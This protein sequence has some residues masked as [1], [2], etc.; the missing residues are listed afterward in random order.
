[1]EEKGGGA[2]VKLFFKKIF[3]QFLDL[4]IFFLKNHKLRA[5]SSFLHSIELD[6]LGYQ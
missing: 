6:P 5:A 1:M 2:G 4:K 3:C